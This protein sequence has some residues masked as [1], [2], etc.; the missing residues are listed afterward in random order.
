MPHYD[1]LV[2]GAVSKDIIITPEDVEH[3]VGGAVVYS[4]VALRHLGAKLL[5]VTK[6][7]PDD[8]A[9]TL[10]RFDAGTMQAGQSFDHVYR[11]IRL[12]GEVRWIHGLAG[13]ERD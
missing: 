6:L 8:R 9:E 2:L 11:F 5:A 13:A 12:D 7:H 1:L 4:S 10:A 3:S